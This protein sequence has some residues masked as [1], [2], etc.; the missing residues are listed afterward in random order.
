MTENIT[1]QLPEQQQEE[2]SLNLYAIIFKY[3]VYWPWFVTSVL[4][5]LIGTFI[6][7]RYQTPVYNISS[8][9][10]IKEQDNK[11]GSSSNPLAAIQELGMMSF[12]NN[13][14]NEVEILKSKTLVKKVVSDLGLYINHSQSR[15]FGYNLPLYKNTPVQ[16]YMTPEEADKLPSGVRLEMDYDGA[17]GLKVLIEYTTLEEED[18][19]IETAFIEL[20]AAL[21]TEIGV[22]T[23]TPDTTVTVDGSVSLVAS[24]ITPQACAANYCE[25]MTISPTSKTTTIANID[26]KNTL[27][28]R[29]V[30][31][32]NHLVEVYNQDAND[33]KNEVAQKTAEFIEERIKIINDEL[34]STE[35]ELATFKQRSGLTDLTSDAQI[36]LQENSR[37]EQQL[38]QNATQIN[39]VQELHQQSGECQRSDSGQ[40]RFGRPELEQHHQP[41]QHVDCRTQAPAPHLFGKQPGRH[42]HEFGYRSHA[43]QRTDY[44]YQCI[45]RTSHHSE[46]PRT[47][48]HQVRRP[49]QQ[50]S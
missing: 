8:S 14:D 7:L 15:S 43:C 19:E 40:C 10:L 4:V 38:T 22:F 36:A 31:F 32:I 9:V 33:E 35:N 30:D 3:L 23:F 11:S 41:V 18:K 13:F 29:G 44:R 47:R 49:Y 5:C 28:Q 37:Y 25:N 6:Y 39:L 46:K 27:K 26:V 20:P 12:T 1:T 24:V 16:V 21:P 34:G 42:Q 45:A 2:D 48:S 17:Q 50:C